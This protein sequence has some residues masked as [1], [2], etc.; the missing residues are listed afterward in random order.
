MQGNSNT[1]TEYGGTGL[2]LS[3]S[4]SLAEA[5]GGDIVVKSK[6]GTGST[7]IFSFMTNL[8][9][10]KVDANDHENTI[11][12]QV[13]ANS[14][15]CRIL[16]AEDNIINQK[17]I[18][19]ILKRLGVMFKV[20]KNGEDCFNEILDAQEKYDIVFMDVRM[21]VMDGLVAT[22]KI[23]SSIDKVKLPKIVGLTA[24]A[25]VEDKEACFAAGMDDYIAKPAKIKD[26]EAV[27]H[28]YC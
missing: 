16:V 19:E 10:A 23:K 11:A 26:I 2:G 25:T 4:K 3:I 18:S 15:N 28:K 22:S 14:S 9:D 13:R 27:I 1:T 17:M 12:E 20:V 5:L 7:F 6:I 24:N 21:P 8:I